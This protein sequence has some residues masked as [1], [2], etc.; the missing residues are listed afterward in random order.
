V[1]TERPENTGVLRSFRHD[2]QRLDFTEFGIS[3][4]LVV[5]LHGQLMP[6]RMQE[7]L[8][9]SLA[10]AG[11]RVVTLDLLG[12]GTSERPSESWRYSMTAW[13][14]QVVAL[15]DHLGVDRAVVGGTSLGAN[16]S[17]EVAV[18]AP[19][20]LRGLL[21][22]MP[23]LDNALVAGLIAFA[24]LLLT[25]RFL[26]RAISATSAAAGLGLRL[27]PTGN[28]LGFWASIVLETLRQQPAPMAAAVEGVFFGRVAPPRSLRQRIAVPALVIG[29][30]RDPIHPFAD[31]GMLVEEM[32]NARLVQARS[33]LELRF[34]PGRL[35]AEIL[36]FLGERFAEPTA[37]THAR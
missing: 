9:G 29:H 5:L 2:G 35:T 27:C 25:A 24:P 8:A 3:D 33:P 10:A 20:R 32:P 21:L 15:L 13:G 26:P 17:L 7:P 14:E 34:A 6:R 28:P 30:R 37:R 23:V 36:G 16:V 4:D 31:A 1:S 11:Y 12:H 18:A 19:E 22:E